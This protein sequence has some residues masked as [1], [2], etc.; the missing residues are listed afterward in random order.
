MMIQQ[1]FIPMRE[2]C[3]CIIADIRLLGAFDSFA[4]DVERPGDFPQ[5]FSWR[6]S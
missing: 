6:P 5:Q 2:L 3:I 4:F 1:P